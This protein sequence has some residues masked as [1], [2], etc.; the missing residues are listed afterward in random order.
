MRKT[1]MRERLLCHS[2][3]ELH[4]E[5]WVHFFFCNAE[6]VAFA[7]RNDNLTV[8]LRLKDICDNFATL[9]VSTQ[10]HW[11]WFRTSRRTLSDYAHRWS[12]GNVSFVPKV[13]WYSSVAFSHCGSNCQSYLETKLLGR[14]DLD[15]I[16]R[17]QRK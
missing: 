3:A 4:S 12:N 11:P 16:E 1:N 9:N 14:G 15:S 13:V 5:F 7:E 6:R 8:W 2:L 10:S 17:D